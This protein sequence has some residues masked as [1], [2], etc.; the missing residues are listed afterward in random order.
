MLAMWQR[1]LVTGYRLAPRRLGRAVLRVTLPSYRVGV[2]AVLRRPDGR[3]LLVDQ[4][5]V[6]GWSLPGGDLKRGEAPADGL[7]REIREELGL[8]L[9]VETPRL[10]AL[11]THDRWVTFVAHLAVDDAQAQA[12]RAASAELDR[13]A[14]FDPADLPAVH[15]D[16]QEPLRLAGVPV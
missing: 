3:V 1:L 10:A 11:R 7:A 14:W 8:E 13:V 4:P 2:L 12:V 9:P 5:Y 16:A 6:E 15:S